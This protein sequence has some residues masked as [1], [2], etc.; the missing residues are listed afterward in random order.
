MF[1]KI[2]CVSSNVSLEEPRSGEGLAAVGTLAALAVGP[3]VHREG[4]HR[5]VHLV[6]VRTTPRLLL[7]D[8]LTLI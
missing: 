8:N 3:H 4:R 5:H 1:K 2:T 7:Y 6:A